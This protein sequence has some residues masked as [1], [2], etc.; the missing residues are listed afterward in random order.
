M[1]ISK[2][3]FGRTT[4]GRE[5]SCWRLTNGS[6][7][8]LEV[9]D[10]GAATRRVEVFGRNVSMS[11]DTVAQYE[12]RTAYSGA[13]VGRHAGRIGG[14]VF[15]LNGKTYKLAV[16][17]GPNHHHGGLEGFSHKIWQAETDG[18]RLSFRYTSPDGEEGFPG[19]LTVTAAY[20]WTAEATLTVTIDAICDRDT[21]ASFTH[22]G[23]WN[24]SGEA[25]V[26]NH[27]YQ[28]H[29]PTFV[30]GDAHNLPTGKL[31]NVTGTPFD[32]RAPQVLGQ[33][34]QGD[35]PQIIPGCG[36]DH[37][38]PVPGEG[39]RE[40]GRLSC[41]DM[42]LTVSSTLPALHLYTGKGTHAALEAQFIPDAIHHPSFPST[43]LPANQQW[44]HTIEY[45]F[46]PCT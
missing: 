14:A 32:F 37:T 34:W 23:Y 2:T 43:I 11:F 5:V 1:N 8:A 33:V 45:K 3:L 28:V 46:T 35:H 21:I 44:H 39:M 17:D 18:R 20:E 36:F 13:I 6:G 22:H 9:L 16:V 10:Y 41:G 25:T 19:T 42:E 7:A 26:G 40:L 15:D 29:A 27:Q 31:V 4:D 38:F 24:L 12:E 30:A